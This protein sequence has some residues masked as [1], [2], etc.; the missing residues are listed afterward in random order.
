M[1]LTIKKRQFL[2]VN[3]FSFNIIDKS[4][5]IYV[6]GCTIIIFITYIKSISSCVC[7]FAQISRVIYTSCL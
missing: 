7:L 4:L 2:N 6:N 5:F 1:F 3:N